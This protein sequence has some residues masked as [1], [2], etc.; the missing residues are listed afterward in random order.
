MCKRFLA[1]PHVEYFMNE[2]SVLV[3]EGGSTGKQ[4]H[5]SQNT[6]PVLTS[7]YQLWVSYGIQG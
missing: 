6:S 3:M 1:M 7:A 2:G 5:T 4:L